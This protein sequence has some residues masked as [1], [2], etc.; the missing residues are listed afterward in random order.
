MTTTVLRIVPG[1]KDTIDMM[2]K[3]GT[4]ETMVPMAMTAMMVLKAT[5]TTMV[6]TNMRGYERYDGTKPMTV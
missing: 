5:I 1:T 6:Q 4:N 3:N 2:V